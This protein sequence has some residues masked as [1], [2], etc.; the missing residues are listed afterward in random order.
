M[1]ASDTKTFKTGKR[2]AGIVGRHRK[3]A[4]QRTK[5]FG[6]VLLIC[7]IIDIINFSLDT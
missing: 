4:E 6:P 5:L 1:F 7:D 2:T 3:G